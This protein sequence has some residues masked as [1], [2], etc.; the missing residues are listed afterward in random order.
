MRRKAPHATPRTL[1]ASAVLGHLLHSLLLLYHYHYHHHHHHHYHYH[2]CYYLLAYLRLALHRFELERVRRAQP[3]Q[4]IRVRRAQPLHA[5]AQ[6]P[7]QPPAQPPAHTPA[8][9]PA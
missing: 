7:S 8:C 4:L 3:R 9:P 5:P 2:C 1:H 6:P